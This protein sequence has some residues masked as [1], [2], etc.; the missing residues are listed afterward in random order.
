M[1]TNQFAATAL[2]LPPIRNLNDSG[3][4]ADS[5]LPL[6]WIN[7]CLIHNF[8]LHLEPETQN[9]PKQNGK[10]FQQ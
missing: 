4:F 9:K 10:Y 1:N 8:V 3:K 5:N 6:F 2:M 7:I